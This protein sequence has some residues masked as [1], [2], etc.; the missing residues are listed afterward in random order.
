VKESSER[1]EMGWHPMGGSYRDREERKGKGK[2]T[3]LGKVG[4]FGNWEQPQG[5]GAQKGGILTRG[6]ERIID[7]G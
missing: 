7:L 4:Q 6:A 3:M 2:K 1:N 5:P